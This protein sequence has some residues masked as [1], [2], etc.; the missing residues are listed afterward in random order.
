M[1]KAYIQITLRVAPENRQKAGDVY[2]MY[3]Q[4]FLTTVTGAKSKDLLL[5]DEDV[6]VLHGFD[7]RAAAEKYLTSAL[8]NEDVVTALTP[9]LT[10]EPE[11]RIYETTKTQ[12]NEGAASFPPFLS[13]D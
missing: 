4:P 11:V 13:H 8:F 2:S 7:S 3:K 9:Y 12:V 1:T 5:R 10:A 6:Q